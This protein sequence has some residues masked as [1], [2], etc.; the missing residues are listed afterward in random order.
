CY[1]PR[2]ASGMFIE[3][4]FIQTVKTVENLRILDLCAAPGGK[5]TH[6]S[7][8]IG[9]DS[10][11][12]SNEVIR[13]R[14]VVLSE[15]VAKWGRA[16]TIVTQNDPAVYGKMKGYF[17]IIMIDAPCSGEGMFRD[18]TA[19]DE[20]SIENARLCEVRQK[21]IIEDVWP[22]LKENGLLIYSTCTFNPGENEENIRWLI[23]NKEAEC[24]SL[25]VLYF[26]GVSEIDYEG[27]YGYGFYPGRVR[28]EGFFISVIRKTSGE[29]PEHVRV[30][31]K[32]EFNPDKADIAF[33]E[34]V[35]MNDPQKLLKRGDDLI[36]LAC[37]TGEFFFL[38]RN[39][40]V[41]SGGTL[42]ATR[43]KNDFL[44]S[45]ELAISQK[46]KMDAFPLTEIS[47]NEALAYLRRDNMVIPGLQDGWNLVTSQGVNL[48]FVKNIGRRINNY[49]PVGWRVRMNMPEPGKENIIRWKNGD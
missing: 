42:L 37:D 19:V 4:A 18:K 16:N 30:Q 26:Q 44:P 7:D 15:T 17:D 34:K 39:L 49:F 46:I 43:K 14:S 21:R 32:S 27:I 48:G 47:Y 8:L 12:V 20:W 41:V 2:E 6:L 36:S 3:Q 1:Y 45:H 25:D 29:K 33:A 35:F 22:S 10:I 5:T 13:P 24:L 38:F 40:S 9:Q 28:G 11:L 23:T 31:R